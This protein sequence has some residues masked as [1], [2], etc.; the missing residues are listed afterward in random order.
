MYMITCWL[1]ANQCLTRQDFIFPSTE[2]NDLI[3]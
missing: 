1:D 2:L 3:L